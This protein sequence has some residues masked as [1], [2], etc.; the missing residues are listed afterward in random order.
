M[1]LIPDKTPP[2]RSPA[3]QHDPVFSWP[4]PNKADYLFWVEKNADLPKNKDFTY[5]E[6]Y[7]G[8]NAQLYPNHRLVF[9]TPQTD[10]KW[11]KWIYASD[12]ITQDAYN[13]EFA[14]ADI[15]GTKFKAVK[16]TYVHLRANFTVAEIIMGTQMPNVPAGLFTGEYVLA[17]RKETR[18][19]EQ[20]LD[21]LFIAEERV[22]VQR[23]T[24]TDINNDPTLGVGVSKVTTLYYRGEQISGTPVETLFADSSNAFWGTL[25]DGVVREGQQISDNWFAVIVTSSLDDARAAYGIS[26]PSITDVKLPSELLGIAVVWNS[27]GG[28]GVFNSEFTGVQASEG[29]GIRAG[30]GGSE[31]ARANGSA[32]VQPE[33]VIN[34]RER[35]GRDVPCLSCFFYIPIV[36]GD[37]LGRLSTVAGVSAS[38]WPRFNPVAHNIV[39]AGMKVQVSAQASGSAS[40][41]GQNV[42]DPITF[43]S[44][45][46]EGSGTDSDYSTM[47]GTKY[48]PPTIHG[49]ITIADATKSQATSATCDVGWIGEGTDTL[50]VD[51]ITYDLKIP[52]VTAAADTGTVNANGFV[53]PTSLAATSPDAIPTSGWYVVGMRSEPVDSRWLRC[54]GEVIDASVFA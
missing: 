11:S 41:D 21:S 54:Y 2:P 24:I 19:P 44:E 3:P 6:I 45:K 52:D 26:V 32:S 7:K 13:W 36:G 16:R 8:S 28:I 48:I 47:V 5:G 29:T 51:G 25:S 50:T 20:E 18:I 35:E 10:D 43:T 22:F 9:V 17:I 40:F 49:A 39:L 15:G 27:D 12:R 33:L 38:Y 4:T 37:F 53:S 23:C 34:I 1:A 30:L 42:S 46:N 31:Q 14:D